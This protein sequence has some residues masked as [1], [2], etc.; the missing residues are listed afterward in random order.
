MTVV[1]FEVAER[2]GRWIRPAVALRGEADLE[3]VPQMRTAIERCLCRPGRR[4]AID[5]SA[6]TFCDVSGLNAFLDGAQHGADS[7]R[8]LTL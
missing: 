6:L 1:P 5:V 7:G 4:M 2:R 3:S 8:H